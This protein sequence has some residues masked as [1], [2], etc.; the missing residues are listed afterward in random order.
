MATNCL[1]T[2]LKGTID[3]DALMKLGELR[4]NVT[5]VS[6]P[7]TTNLTLMVVNYSTVEPE[8]VTY[9]TSTYIVSNTNGKLSFFPKYQITVIRNSNLDKFNMRIQNTPDDIFNNCLSLREIK[10][11]F[12]ETLDIT[13]FYKYSCPALEELIMEKGD[14]KGNISGLA[15]HTAFTYLGF[16]YCT[17]ITGEITSLANLTEL[18]TLYLTSTQVSGELADLATAQVTNGR[19]SGILSIYVNAIITSNGV[20]LSNRTRVGIY[21]GTSMEGQ[22]PTADET[23]QGWCIR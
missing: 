20:H 5:Q 19:T 13:D 17:N 18:T 10:A 12:S 1:V 8:G 7:N 15:N 16:N 23:T 22:N 21:F 11:N 3:N 9:D 14:V 4:F 6:S 2:K